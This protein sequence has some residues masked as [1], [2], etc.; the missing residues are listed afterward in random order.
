MK[1]EGIRISG[2]YPGIGAPALK[3]SNMSCYLLERQ[4][5]TIELRLDDEANPEFWL[6]IK[7]SSLAALLRELVW[8]HVELLLAE[9]AGGTLDL[10]QQAQLLEVAML[11]DFEFIG[12]R[13]WAMEILEGGKST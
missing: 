7:F 4:G 12:S 2:R 1:K 10:N 6:Q 8:E 9:I 13:S 3:S 5:P 11:H